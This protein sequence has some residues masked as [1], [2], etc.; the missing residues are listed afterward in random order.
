M[1][2]LTLNTKHVKL[3]LVF[4]LHIVVFNQFST[5]GKMHT[6]Q[7]NIQREVSPSTP[8][9]GTMTV[10]NVWQI[11]ERFV[12]LLAGKEITIVTA[13]E[14]REYVPEVFQRQKLHI[15]GPKPSFE[16]TCD[17]RVAELQVAIGPKFKFP[18]L[19]T[20]QLISDGT[21]QSPHNPRF[22]FTENHVTVTWFSKT[23]AKYLKNYIVLYV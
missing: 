12:D 7:E 22:E 10:Q 20:V 14:K 19:A 13:D 1:S 5:E 9:T 18:K 17:N 15:F 23:T 11:C 2:Y 21:F 4:V 3:Y 6:E 16:V 8:W